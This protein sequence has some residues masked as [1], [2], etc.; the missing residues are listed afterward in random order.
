[1]PRN[2]QAEIDAEREGEDM[3]DLVIEESEPQ[4]L[5]EY[6]CAMTG[7]DPDKAN[8]DKILDKLE[9]IK[10]KSVTRLELVVE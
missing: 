1:M 5:W 9:D 6:I 10:V 4:T 8:V 3:E 7:E 2:I